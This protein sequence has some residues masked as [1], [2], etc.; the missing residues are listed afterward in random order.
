[1]LA[2]FR[3]GFEDKNLTTASN[4]DGFGCLILM[5][6]LSIDGFED[7]VEGPEGL[8]L[9]TVSN[10]EG[11]EG[12]TEILEGLNLQQ[13]RTLRV[14]L[15]VMLECLLS[16]AHSAAILVSRWQ[17]RPESEDSFEH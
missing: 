1:M 13:F 15:R 6:S 3:D 9:T 8:N 17:W 14:C 4:I 5:T 2:E 16:S 11:L 10:I 7:P 12:N